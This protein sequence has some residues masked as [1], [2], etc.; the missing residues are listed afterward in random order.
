MHHPRGIFIIDDGVVGHP[1]LSEQLTELGS[2]IQP[3]QTEHV[4]KKGF[5]KEAY[6]IPLYIT[7]YIKY[8]SS[9]KGKLFE[10]KIFYQHADKSDAGLYFVPS[11]MRQELDSKYADEF[12][13]LK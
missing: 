11:K 9:E 3:N 13:K 8:N 6:A 2:P 10:E 5:S 7:L 1:Y 4:V 12:S